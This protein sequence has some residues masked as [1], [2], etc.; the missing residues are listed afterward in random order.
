MLFLF[1]FGEFSIIII[2]I[3]IIVIVRSWRRLLSVQQLRKMR[4]MM[5]SRY[6]VH[7]YRSPKRIAMKWLA[8]YKIPHSLN[9]SG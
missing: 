2:E 4:G 7:N 9:P 5:M 8:Q 1:R 6:Q 3:I